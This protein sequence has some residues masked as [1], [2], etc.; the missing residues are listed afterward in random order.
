[1]YYDTCI[2]Q[3]L[4]MEVELVRISNNY[5]LVPEAAEVLLQ[6]LPLVTACG[7]RQ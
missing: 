3:W 4:S 6:M 5:E 7:H 2:T 1:M